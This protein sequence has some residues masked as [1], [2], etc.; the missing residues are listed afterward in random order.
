MKEINIVYTG[1]ID[2]KLDNKIISAMN[3]IDVYFMHSE[4][5]TRDWVRTLVMRKEKNGKNRKEKDATH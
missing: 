1:K 4:Y 2:H 3:S 5:D